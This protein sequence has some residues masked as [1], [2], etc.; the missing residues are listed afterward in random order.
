MAIGSSPA[1]TADRLAV[2]LLLLVFGVSAIVQTY[3][4]R[5][6][7]EDDRAGWFSAGGACSPPPRPS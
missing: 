2:V 6:L 4:I 1:V 5:Y 3:A 7:A